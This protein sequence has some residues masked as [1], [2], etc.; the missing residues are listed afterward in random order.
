MAFA[1]TKCACS[2]FLLYENFSE[3]K[4]VSEL[5]MVGLFL[6]LLCGQENKCLDNQTEVGGNC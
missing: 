2:W 4:E 5:I 3:D 6:T 1:L